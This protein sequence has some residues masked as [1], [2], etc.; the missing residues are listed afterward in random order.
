VLLR[1][2]T[3]RSAFA[4]R[5]T[6]LYA[7]YLPFPYVH[8]SFPEKVEGVKV[9][10]SPRCR[11]AVPARITAHGKVLEDSGIVNIGTTGA[12]IETAVP[13]PDS[14]GTI[15]ITFSFELHGVPVSLNLH[16]RVRGAKGATGKEDAQRHQYGVEFKDLQ[17]NDRVV[18][19][20]LVYFRM[21][22][23]PESVA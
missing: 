20:S 22:E 21:Y 18:L 10:S 8:L 2:F 9:R 15:E 16:A 14:D 23:H 1:A 13:L 7:A 5:S 11:F 17:P 6:V 4:F 19:G 3:G 12:L